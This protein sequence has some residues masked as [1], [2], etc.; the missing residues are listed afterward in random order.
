MDSNN[1]RTHDY[2]TSPIP[3]PPP[4]PTNK[5]NNN[6]TCTEPSDQPLIGNSGYAAPVWFDEIHNHRMFSKIRIEL[7][8]LGQ[9]VDGED[10]L[11]QGQDVQAVAHTRETFTNYHQELFVIDVSGSSNI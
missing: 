5:Q 10:S 8:G 7:G 3:A 6:Q 9:E 2:S 1:Y 4:M 11:G